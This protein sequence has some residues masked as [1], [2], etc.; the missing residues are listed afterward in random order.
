MDRADWRS[1]RGRVHG[2]A[3]SPSENRTQ[4]RSAQQ[5]G[6]P[7]RPTSRLLIEASLEVASNDSAGQ[8]IVNDGFTGD[9]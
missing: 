8:E 5:R 6:D 3:L 7:V 4:S 9:V 1:G 2:D